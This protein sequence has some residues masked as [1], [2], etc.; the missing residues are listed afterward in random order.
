MNKSV[1]ILSFISVCFALVVV[2]LG[3]KI[4]ISPNRGE[5]VLLWTHEDQRTLANRLKSAG[6]NLQAIQEYENYIKSA[7]IDKKQL[8]GLS[9][10]IGEMYMQAGQ[11]EKALA[12]FY[13]VEIADPDSR[14]K[15]EVGSKIINCLERSGKYAA[16]EYSLSKRASHESADTQKTG[17][18]VAE[19]GDEKIYLADLNAAIDGMPDWMRKRFEDKES[20]AEYL[21]KYVA[22]ELFYRKA[23]KLEYDKDPGV[24]KKLK[25]LGREIIVNKVLE[26]ELKDKIKV[27]DED[28]RNYFLAHKQDYARKEA[29]KVSLIKAGMREIADKI[30]EELKT[31][32]DFNKLAGKISLDKGT[33]NNGGKFN[34]WVR[35]GEDDLGI[36]NVKEVARVLFAAE[37]GEVS[38]PV[39]AGE[40]YY[41]FR[42][43]KKRPAKPASFDES[44]EQVKND[45]FMQKL[46]ISYQS[47]LDQILKTSEVK[48]FPE[49]V[50]GEGSS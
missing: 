10:T 39:E 21:K 2:F 12:W 14:L 24:R 43:D 13:R 35:K 45:Y 33:A 8:S 20:K 31:G 27:E 18:V 26:E 19:I 9:Y 48:F 44:R 46:K 49:V 37:T 22:D 41:I 3:F 23:L 11:Y 17:K 47:L 34:G 29:V 30:I 25:A 32:K 42:V 40:Y 50:S 38:A 28:L 1:I 4:G 15:A 36:G 5:S 16:A 7:P 6:L